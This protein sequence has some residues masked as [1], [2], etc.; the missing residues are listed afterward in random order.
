M[1]LD[2][3]FFSGI[4][5]TLLKFHKNLGIILALRSFYKISYSC[6]KSKAIKNYPYGSL[7]AWFLLSISHHITKLLTCSLF[8]S[9]KGTKKVEI[10]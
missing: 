1:N 6:M 2:I 7:I 4:S 8:G 5:I 9:A 10:C 3:S